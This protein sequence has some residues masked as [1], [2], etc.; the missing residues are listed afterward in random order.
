MREVKALGVW[1]SISKEEA[2][3]LNYQ[4]KK[5]KISKGAFVWDIP[6][7]EYIPE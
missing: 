5:E 6:E 4:E 1:F 7:L 2:V 3:M